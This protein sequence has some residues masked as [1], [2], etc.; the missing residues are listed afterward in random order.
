MRVAISGSSGLIGSTL[1]DALEARGSG[2]VR[3]VRSGGGTPSRVLWSTDSGLEETAPLEGVDALVHLAG[4]GIAD[5]RWSEE[6]KRLILSSRV[7]G[8]R[9]L[10]AAC[11]RLERPPGRFLCASAIGYYGDRGDEVLHEGSPAGDGFLAEVCEAW[12]REAAAAAAWAG[13]VYS[14]RTGIVLSTDGGA[15]PKMLTPFK[16]GLGGVLGSG[17]QYM[18]WISIDDEVGAILHLLDAELDSGPVNLTAPA[19][20]TNRQFTKALGSELRRP[21]IFPVPEL[22]IKTLFGQMGEEA[23]LGSQQVLPA[24]LES[25]GYTFHHPTL[26]GALQAV[27]A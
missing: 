3:L 12:E 13:R 2:V 23:L 9:N 8:T 7:E 21:T 18:S 1:A 17:E 20:A 4:A 27:L 22:A 19:P 15:L 10:V 24:R 26:E 11:A 5:K 25:S 6:R 16:L 14:L